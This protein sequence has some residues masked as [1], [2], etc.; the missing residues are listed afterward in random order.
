MSQTLEDRIAQA[1]RRAFENAGLE[2]SPA[3]DGPVPLDRL[4]GDFELEHEEIPGLTR[5]RAAAT[6]ARYGIDCAALPCD[7]T[8]LA[9]LICADGRRGTV[10][11]CG[12]DPLTRRRFSAAHELGHY[13]LHFDPADETGTFLQHDTAETLAEPD[14]GDD[15]LE[16]AALEREANRFAAELLMPAAAVRR[17]HARLSARQRLTEN[18]LANRIA[19]ELLVS[20]QAALWRL[21]ELGCLDDSDAEE[22]SI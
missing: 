17:L 19:G 1:V 3:G 8:P 4:I 2:W 15:W 12:D 6:L 20:R 7:A 22:Q 5:G 9:G 11:V 21:R 10:F 14:A 18:F 16:L 13:L